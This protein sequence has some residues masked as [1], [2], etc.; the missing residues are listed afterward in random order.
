MQICKSSQKIFAQNP[1]KYD[2]K[3]ILKK[4]HPCSK[5]IAGTVECRFA[6]ETEAK[7]LRKIRSI[8]EKKINFFRLW[9]FQKK[10]LDAKFYSET[11]QFWK[12]CRKLFWNPKNLPSKTIRKS[13][14]SYFILKN[15]QMF[16]WTCKNKFWHSF[17][18]FSAKK[19]TYF[20]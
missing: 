17:W 10:S 2:F 14:K 15:P 7:N 4:K 6:I 19:W 16:L 1:T 5:S 12:T 8:S 11:T 3:S 18:Q 20:C 13:D 9:F